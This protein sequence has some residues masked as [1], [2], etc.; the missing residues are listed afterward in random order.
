M[1]KRFISLSWTTS[2]R[3]TLTGFLSVL[4]FSFI[5]GAGAPAETTQDG[6][7]TTH[8]TV[9]D[10][11]QYPWSAVGRVNVSG[12]S[13]RSH[14]TG[15]LIGERLVLTAAHCL[16][17]QPTNRY[18]DP[19]AV[20]FVAGYQDRGNP[21]QKYVA[22]STAFQIIPSQGFVGEAWE[23]SSNLQHDWALIILNEPIGRVT[24]YLGIQALDQATLDQLTTDNRFFLLAGYP[25]DRAHAI[26]VDD[27][28]NIVGFLNEG[29]LLSH[30][31]QIVGGDSGAPIAIQTENG[32]RV[33]GLNSATNVGLSDGS[34]TNTA[35]P[36]DTLLGLV[37]K[38]I[39]H[40]ETTPDLGPGVQRSGMPPES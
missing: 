33:I 17:Y 10:A 4:V 14:C 6:V 25:R 19:R 26:S 3:A 31:C 29:R 20:H 7:T 13:T 40:T 11:F 23:A 12:V 35:V 28:C 5:F 34:V 36:I 21:D 1:V 18:A 9:V 39:H 38:A 30:S 37:E 15:A 32:L 22:H 24:G 8:R 16:Y 2:G 27:Q